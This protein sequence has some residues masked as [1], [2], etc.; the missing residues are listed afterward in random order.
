M[1]NHN[2][3][4]GSLEFDIQEDINERIISRSMLILSVEP[5]CCWHI[6][7]WM[8]QGMISDICSKLNI[9]LSVCLFEPEKV[10]KKECRTGREERKVKN[11]IITAFL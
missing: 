5:T 3:H 7:V 4:P 2:E 1:I 6:G 11:L 10:F 8:I 9:Q